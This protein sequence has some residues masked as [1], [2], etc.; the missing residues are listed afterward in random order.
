[1]NIDYGYAPIECAAE[2]D[3]VT[4]EANL[5]GPNPEDRTLRVFVN[6]REQP[7]YFHSL[8]PSIRFSFVQ[9]GEN[10]LVKEVSLDAVESPTGGFDAFGLPVVWYSFLDIISRHEDP[11][12]S[13]SYGA[14]QFLSAL[15][16]FFN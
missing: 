10:V 7:I 16:E 8:P 3:V 6:N 9:S 2:G 12:S 14:A 4:I 1:M 11:E 15:M 5:V 13:V